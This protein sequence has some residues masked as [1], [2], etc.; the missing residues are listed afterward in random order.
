MAACAV[1]LSDQREAVAACLKQFESIQDEINLLREED[2][3]LS[4]RRTEFSQV[5]TEQK[6]EMAK[7]ILHAKHANS[8]MKRLRSAAEAKQSQ[9]TSLEAEIVRGNEELQRN[10]VRLEDL[11]AEANE[12]ETRLTEQEMRSQKI[13]LQINDKLLALASIEQRIESS[14]AA[15]ASLER[16]LAKLTASHA[17]AVEELKQIEVKTAEIQ[18]EQV[19]QTDALRHELAGLM[20]EREQLSQDESELRT[21][22]AL[23]QE[24]LAAAS[25]AASSS[26]GEGETVADVSLERTD[27]PLETVPQSAS[28]L[29]PAET[30]EVESEMPLVV[31]DPL[32]SDVWSSVQ[33]LSQMVHD[34][35]LNESVANVA[36]GGLDPWATVLA[37]VASRGGAGAG[38]NWR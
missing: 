16:H 13:E 22:I 25:L 18:A 17:Q 8:G 14:K 27:D 15:K 4:L 6:A 31:D 20:S 3:A 1:E 37:D 12:A 7:L 28:E 26:S 9:L 34:S 29:V 11:R 36:G 30:I 10:L 33:E 23:L 2:V 5:I 21:S 35:R 38:Q 32:V 19:R 24:S